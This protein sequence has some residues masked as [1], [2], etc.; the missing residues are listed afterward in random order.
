MRRKF[1]LLALGA[2]LG[3][4]LCAIGGTGDARAQR[5]VAEKF[6]HQQIFWE[7]YGPTAGTGNGTKVDTVF[8][9][10]AVQ[11]VD[12]T[13]AVNTSEWGFWPRNAPV[14]AATAICRVGIWCSGDGISADS[15]F[16]AMDVGATKVG[17]WQTGGT[18]VGGVAATAGDDFLSIVL[19]EDVDDN[20][21]VT[22]ASKLFGQQWVRFRVRVDGNT[23]AKMSGARFLLSYPAW[24]N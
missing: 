1:A 2:M 24:E 15:V 11:T 5:G 13:E 10:G 22:T 17:P 14:V 9:D 6:R 21:G 23:A 7:Q 20:S 19:L 8:L 3:I 4:M 18:F 12:T 16:V